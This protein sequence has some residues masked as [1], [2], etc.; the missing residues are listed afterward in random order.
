MFVHVTVLGEK[1]AQSVLGEFIESVAAEMMV[2]FFFDEN[3]DT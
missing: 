3:S 1:P 2:L